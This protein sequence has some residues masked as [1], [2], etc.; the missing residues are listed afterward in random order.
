MSNSLAMISIA[1]FALAWLVGVTAW[2]ATL[3]YGLKTLRHRKP[4][5]NLWSSETLWNPANILLRPGLLTSEGLVY[6]RRCFLSVLIFFLMVGSSL[7]FGALTGTL[8]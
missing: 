8:K 2:L 6:R 1:A 5:V 4:G 3:F 7:M